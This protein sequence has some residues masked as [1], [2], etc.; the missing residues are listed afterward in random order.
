MVNRLEIVFLKVLQGLAAPAAG[1]AMD[2]VVFGFIESVDS[3]LEIGAVEVNVRGSGNVEGS[4]FFGSADIEDDEIGLGE[5]FLSTPGIDMLDRSRSGGIGGI[6]GQKTEREG[7]REESSAMACGVRDHIW[8][9]ILLWLMI[10]PKFRPR[11]GV[12]NS[13]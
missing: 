8:I 12:V 6:G 4:E 5:Q 2:Q 11:A 3:L 9:T 7:E 10:A 1:S 13:V